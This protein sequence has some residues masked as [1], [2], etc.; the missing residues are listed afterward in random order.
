MSVSTHYKIRT[1]LTRC[2]LIEAV[3]VSVNAIKQ[4]SINGGIV[5]PVI[6]IPLPRH[7]RNKLNCNLG[8]LIWSVVG[9]W[10]SVG[11][12]Y[13]RHSDEH[14]KGR[15]CPSVMHPTAWLASATLARRATCELLFD[16]PNACIPVCENKFKIGSNSITCLYLCRA[17]DISLLTRT[18]QKQT[19]FI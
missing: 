12:R 8:P 19:A 7:V 14:T 11:L 18:Q 16:E 1:T 10:R 2:I 17:F 9:Y 15:R 6:A 3:H 5:L 4:P 13:E